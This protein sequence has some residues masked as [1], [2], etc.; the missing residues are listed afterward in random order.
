MFEEYV[1]QSHVSFVANPDYN[2][3]PP[4]FAHEGRPYL[5]RVVIRFIPDESTRVAA[6]ETGEVD[7]IKDVPASAL[8][9]LADMGTWTIVEQELAGPGI[10]YV[11]NASRAPLD[12]KL[13]RQALL[14]ATDQEE[15]RDL[16]FQEL[17]SGSDARAITYRSANQQ[18]FIPLDSLRKATERVNESMKTNAVLHVELRS[19]LDSVSGEELSAVKRSEIRTELHKRYSF[20]LACLTFA[21]VGI[22]LG[23]TAQRRETSSG[24]VL[25]LAVACLYFVFVIVADNMRSRPEA[26]PHL[27]M[28]IPNVVFL[29]VGSLLFWRLSRK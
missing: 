12:D 23:V 11:P 9:M 27:L 2:W 28:W 18:L 16:V 20:S 8:N 25:S 4:S 29:L 22:P 19:R 24:F 10:H 26:M 5:D 1:A 21:L 3:A 13:V 14:Y 17:T 15:I 7:A 6:L